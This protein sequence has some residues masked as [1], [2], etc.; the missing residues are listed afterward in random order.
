MSMQDATNWREQFGPGESVQRIRPRESFDYILNPHKGTTTYQRF[1]GE[2]PEPIDGHWCD[3][4]PLPRPPYSGTTKNVGYTDTTVVYLRWLWKTFEP[5]RG[6]RNWAILDE[7]LKTAG[8]RGQTVQFR[9]NTYD[10]GFQ[11]WWYWDTGGKTAPGGDE[12]DINDPNWFE[13]LGETIRELGQ[14]YDGHPLLDTVDAVYGGMW[15]EGGGNANEETTA[16]FI[17]LYTEAF[18]KTHVMV[19]E[20]E[21]SM[22]CAAKKKLG[23]RA[24]CFG[25]QRRATAPG[26]VPDDLCWNHMMDRYP[27]IVAESGC[28]DNWRHGP[29]TME[30]CWTVGYWQK[31]GW[32][33]DWIIDQGMKYHMTYFMPK[34]CAFPDEW[35]DK[36]VDFNKKM[37][38]RFV[39]RQMMMPL[40]V[41]RG[42]AIEVKAWIDNLGCAPIYKPYKFALQIRQGKRSEVVPFEFDIRTWMPGYT[43]FTEQVRMPDWMEDGDVQVDI[44]LVDEQGTPRVRFAVMDVAEDGWYPATQMRVAD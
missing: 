28:Q 10:I 23:W 25:D 2:A 33:L 3:A 30:S 41:Q 29:V 16:A 1:N 9:L 13:C 20:G 37:G 40:D 12:P 34:S 36:L 38:Y 17:D 39:P 32:D 14:R 27:F 31:K 6:K 7:Y 18:K 19:M 15:G 35:M 5:E 26:I 11:D 4:G 8:E 42:Q 43:C 21:Y 24:D 44:G 22:A